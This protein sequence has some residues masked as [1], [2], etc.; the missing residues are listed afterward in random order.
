MCVI[1]FG[2][3][4]RVPFLFSSEISYFWGKKKKKGLIKYNC[5]IKSYICL[6]AEMKGG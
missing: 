6:F 1:I 2:T 4:C 3:R 5:K